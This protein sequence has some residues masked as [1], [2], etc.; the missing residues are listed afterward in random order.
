MLNNAPPIISHQRAKSPEGV[1]NCPHDYLS[2]PRPIQTGPSINEICE[3]IKAVMFCFSE[4][5]DITVLDTRLAVERYYRTIYNMLSSYNL[6]P[7]KTQECSIE[8]TKLFC[9]YYQSPR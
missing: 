8:C 4:D 5:E 9:L 2:A 6:G 3:M 7:K 1:D